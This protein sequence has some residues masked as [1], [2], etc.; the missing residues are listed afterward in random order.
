MSATIR[1]PD[2]EVSVDTRHWIGG[3]PVAMGT[4][5][6]PVF[7]PI[8]GQ[9]LGEVAAGGAVE[10]DR[11]VRAARDAFPAWAALGPEGRGA[12]LDRFAQAILEHRP[13]LSAVETV[14]N[15]SLLIAN[16]KRIV[17]RAAHNISYFAKA[18]RTLEHPAIA[19]AEV[20][21]R[22]RYEPAGVAA[23]IT[24]WNA[25]L[26]LST[27]KIGPALAA[28]NTVVLKPP[29]WAPLSCSLLAQL[30][31]AAGVPAGVFNVVQ[32]LGSEA[33]Q[34][35]AEHPDVDRISFTGST[36]TGRRVAAAAANN[37]TPVSLELG[38]KSPFIVF[39]DADL[40]DA[41]ANVA[42]QFNNAGQVCLAGTRILVEAS[43]DA[44]FRARVLKAAQPYAVG[45]PR[46]KGVRVGPLIHPRQLERV[47][48]FVSRALEAGAKPLLG[49]GPHALGGLYYQPTILTDV[50]PDAEII[51]NEVFGPVLTWQ[52]FDRE[53]EAIEL[54]NATD[55][56]LAAMVYTRDSAKAERVAAS[57]VAGTV[58]VNCYFVR[59]LGAPFGGARHS[60]VGREGGV[61]SFDFFCDVKN[62]AVKRGTFGG[63]SSRG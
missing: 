38:G 8:D 33:G 46:Q 30:A 58:W 6:F 47:S 14:D 15:G 13:Q 63:E 37:I 26:M 35:L 59:E 45:D 39:A 1:I 62:V 51:R 19:S 41:A 50:Q 32:G 44:D 53:A 4:R 16:Q 31:A 23:L 3:A 55:Y 43:V 20:D 60:G 28:G 54:A 9:S 61:W 57:V 48:G 27:W 42:A 21:N 7:S 12:I 22:V 34:A 52:T 36:A 56:G 10:V 24:P 40:D 2:S 18:A 29:E 49:G 5:T 17:E 11:A 25:P